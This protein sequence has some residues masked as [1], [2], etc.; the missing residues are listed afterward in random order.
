[1]KGILSIDGYDRRFVFHVSSSP[2]LS[3]HSI[4]HTV[5]PACFSSPLPFARTHLL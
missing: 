3:F 2:F 5:V 4:T 1:M